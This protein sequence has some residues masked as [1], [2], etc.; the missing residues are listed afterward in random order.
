MKAF[1]CRMCGECCY[2]EGGI[3][4][5]G[6]EIERISRFLGITA[7][8]FL[9]GYCEERHAR[10][11]IKTGPDGFCIFFDRE[12]GC[13]IHPVKPGP[14]ELWPFYPAIVEDEENW[15]LAKDACP[16]INPDC[17]FEEFVK[18]SKTALRDSGP[19]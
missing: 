1:Q 2:G 8:D 5:E 18:E 3:L 15:E 11:Y 13:L 14:C 7:S 19:S 4:V 17:S 16:G 6:E 9:S 12:K 10:T